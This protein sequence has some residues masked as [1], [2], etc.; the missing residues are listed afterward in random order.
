MF[1]ARSRILLRITI[2]SVRLSSAAPATHELTKHWSWASILF[3]RYQ[4]WPFNIERAKYLEGGEWLN[5]LETETEEFCRAVGAH[6]S[7]SS[8]PRHLVHPI[9][10][11]LKDRSYLW[12]SCL[13]RP[14]TTYQPLP[15]YCLTQLLT[16]VSS[17]ASRKLGL[18]LPTYLSTEFQPGPVFNMDSKPQWCWLWWERIRI[19]LFS[20]DKKTSYFWFLV[21]YSTTKKNNSVYFADG[22][23]IIS[24]Y[25]II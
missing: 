12:Y 13:H 24:T 6:G 11:R 19:D 10:W 25:S 8:E 1:A 21:P 23:C 3:S 14:I 17:R 5:P 2:L 15:Y 20:I 16:V 4:W 7:F 22:F 9:S 18:D